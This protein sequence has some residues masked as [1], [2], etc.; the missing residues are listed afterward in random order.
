M[1]G[2]KFYSANRKFKTVSGA[3]NTPVET[4]MP[5]PMMPFADND[6]G[7]VTQP[8]TQRMWD[9]KKDNGGSVMGRRSYEQTGTRPFAKYK[10]DANGQVSNGLEDER[11]KTKNSGGFSGRL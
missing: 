8:E 7:P 10:A 1:R 6:A 11:T 5:T 2:K 4:T 9:P 3:N